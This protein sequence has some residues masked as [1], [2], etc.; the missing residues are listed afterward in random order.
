MK[1]YGI[2]YKIPIEYLT[3]VGSDDIQLAQTPIDEMSEKELRRIMEKTFLIS[4]LNLFP[5]FL[6]YIFVQNQS[7]NRKRNI[8]KLT[9]IFF[10]SI[11]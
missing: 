10:S 8:L 3:I 2:F 7:K 4:H 1:T 5:Y 6:R 11:L 9:Q